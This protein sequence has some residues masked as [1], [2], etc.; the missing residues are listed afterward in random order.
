MVGV[1]S[2]DPNIFGVGIHRSSHFL[3]DRDECRFCDF[4]SVLLAVEPAQSRHHRYTRVTPTDN[5]RNVEYAEPSLTSLLIG[6]PEYQH[7]L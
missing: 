2:F 7:Q 5:N 4:L 6:E 3:D 1:D